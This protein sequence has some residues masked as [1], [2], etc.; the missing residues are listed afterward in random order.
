[1]A[2]LLMPK[3]GLTMTEGL[4]AEWRIKPKQP[5]SSGDVLFV[6][7]TEKI[8]NEVEAEDSGMI[9]EVLVQAGETVAVGTPVARTTNVDASETKHQ[10]VGSGAELVSPPL[11]SIASSNLPESGNGFIP[12]RIVA[13][14]LARRIARKV[15]VDLA[16]ISGSGPR[17]RIKAKDVEHFSSRNPEKDE[18]KI[19]GFP[20]GHLTD[21]QITTARRVSQS[22]NEVPHFYISS[23]AEI[24]SLSKLR[25]ELNEDRTLPKLSITHLLIKA[26]GLALARHPL[27][28]RVWSENRIVTVGTGDV[29][30]V[31]ETS[32]GLRLPVIRNASHRPL[33]QLAS[34]ATML[35]KKAREGGLSARDIGGGAISISNLGM[36]GIKSLTPIINQP[37]AM[38]LGVGSENRLFRPD[39]KGNPVSRREIN[40]TLSCDHRVMDGADAARFLAS[41]VELLEYPIR[42]LRVAPHRAENSLNQEK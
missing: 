1:M 18:T 28:D 30:L 29:G 37:Q 16:S 38:M 10:P 31:V 21:A 40:L 17:G 2:D 24:S 13:T 25:S 22:K 4:L 27:A 3:L 20:A 19:L 23:D 32:N 42:L 39:E 36:F 11:P 26:V 8:A 41:V 33:D 14:P 7:E 35:V 15:G 9:Q 5:F 6:V 12:S 34:E